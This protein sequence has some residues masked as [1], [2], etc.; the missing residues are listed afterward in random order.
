VLVQKCDSAL[1][2]K[3]VCTRE[4]VCFCIREKACFCTH[5]D[6]IDF[7]R[8][9]VL[10]ARVQESVPAC[11]RSRVR[12][13]QT[14]LPVSLLGRG[15]MLNQHS[16]SC[17]CVIA[18]VLLTPSDGIVHSFLTCTRS[19]RALVPH[20]HSFRTCTSSAR[21]LVPHVHSFRTCTRSARALVPH[22]HSFLTW[23]RSSWGRSSH[24]CTRSHVPH[25]HTF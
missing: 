4:K 20:V 3:S 18:R 23:A 19:S 6:G 16:R 17:Q 10:G 7:A 22:V 21:A 13:A 5:A 9:N 15:R 14:S 11:S 1:V 8:E 24:T 2:Q 25:V 12:S